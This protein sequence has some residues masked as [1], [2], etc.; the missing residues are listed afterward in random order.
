MYSQSRAV[1]FAFVF[2]WIISLLVGCSHVERTISTKLPAYA[3]LPNGRDPVNPARYSA[4]GERFSK[5]VIPSLQD[6]HGRPLN[7]L[8]ISGG[9]AKGAFGSGVLI[10]WAESGTRPKFDIVTGISAGALLSTFAFLGEPEDD[11]VIA[12][13]FTTM[14]ND[15]VSPKA[16]GVLRFAFGDNSLMDNK[17]LIAMLR[18][19]I[20]EKTLDRVAAESRKGRL[21]FVGLFNLDYRELWAFDLTGLAASGEPD[22][23]D[24]YRKI[25]L[26][27]ASPPLIFPPVEINGS[28]YADGGTRDRLLVVGLGGSDEG[29][30]SLATSGGTFYVIFNDQAQS[31]ARAVNP[32]IKG[33]IGSTIQTMLGANMEATL[34]RAYLA[35]Q[36]HGYHFKLMKIPDDVRL[37]P[38][39][40]SFDPGTMKALFEKG[41]TLGRNPTSWVAAPPAGENASPWLIKVLSELRSQR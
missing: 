21:L 10:G 13:L 9:G 15:D 12:D 29:S 23:L 2:L 8:E 22:A 14:K 39:S 20:T 34:L 17:P 7:I 36:A 30:F 28:L 40:F 33:L 27:S 38:E 19:L 6:W 32:D 31:E 5:G 3:S 11:A 35:A 41:R 4:L 16:G 1:R 24:T 18:K 37:E 26:A 25:L